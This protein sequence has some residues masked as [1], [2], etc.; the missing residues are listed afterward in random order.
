MVSLNNSLNIKCMVLFSTIC[1]GFKGKRSNPEK[2]ETA[3]AASV[4]EVNRSPAAAVTAVNF[5][6]TFSND[7]SFLEQ[8]KK[9]K[10]T[11]KEEAPSIKSETPAVPPKVEEIK[12]SSQEED[13][14][15]SA[16]AR[17]KQIAQNMS[18]EPST[19]SAVKSEPQGNTCFYKAY[20]RDTQ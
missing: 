17:A 18:M 8:F 4:S 2:V 9:M 19:S 16:L 11:T 15:K 7:G 6:N 13:W 5:K 1:R 3:Q 10:Q 20:L 14:Y 12:P